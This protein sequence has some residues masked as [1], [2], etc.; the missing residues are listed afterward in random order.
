M[1]GGPC[2]SRAPTKLM[3]LVMAHGV[4]AVY[5]AVSPSVSR[6]SAY[7]V[8]VLGYQEANH[9]FAARSR[10]DLGQ[11]AQLIKPAMLSV[12]KQWHE[13]FR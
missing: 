3:P 11:A 7:P 10:H 12:K 9:F 4:A 8:W 5:T 2:P 13:R 6:P 1:N